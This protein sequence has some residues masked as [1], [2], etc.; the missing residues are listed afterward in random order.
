MTSGHSSH[1][2]GLD[3][4]IW[5]T[6]PPKQR[7]SRSEREQIGAESVVAKDRIHLNDRWT[8]SHHAILKLAGSDPAVARIFVNPAIKRRLCEDEPAGDR[9][10]LRQI[11][12]WWGHDAHFHVRLKC[13]AGASGCIDQAPPDPGDGCDG[14][15]AWWFS[16]EALHPK[17]P[18]TPA[19]PRPDLTLADLPPECRA[20]L[21]LN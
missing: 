14:S 12:P 17:P 3:V 9:A 1:Q 11:R 6:R 20:V 10:W 2:I 15:L 4:D 21:D 13:P 16:D 18:K 8:P 5:L 7:L 19:K